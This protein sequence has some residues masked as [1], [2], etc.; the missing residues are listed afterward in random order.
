LQEYSDLYKKI[1][2]SFLTLCLIVLFPI[3][4][5]N[6]Q[7]ESS[8]LFVAPHRIVIASHERIAVIN[9]AN[10]SNEILRYDLAMIDQVM[11]DQ[12]LT[13]RRDNFEYSARRMLRFVPGPKSPSIRPE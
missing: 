13:Q 9:V 6:A 7:L 4:R 2:L 12:G 10:K 8:I 3:T 11:N 5:G 1:I